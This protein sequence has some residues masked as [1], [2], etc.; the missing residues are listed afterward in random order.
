VPNLWGGIIAPPGFMKS[1]VIEAT[2]RPLTQIEAEWRAEHDVE[3][4]EYARAKEECELRHGAWRE[5]YKA[6][7]KKG[8]A[9]PERPEDELKIRNCDD[10]S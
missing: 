6:N 9:T 4:E 3:L 8:I 10:S 5:S 2:T 7:A 1:P